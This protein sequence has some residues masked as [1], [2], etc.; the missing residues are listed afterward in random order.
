MMKT[1]SRLL[2]L[3][4]YPDNLGEGNWIYLVSNAYAFASAKLVPDQMG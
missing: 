3:I 4:T 1:G 2:D